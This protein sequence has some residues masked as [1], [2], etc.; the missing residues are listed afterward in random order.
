[1]GIPKFFR[2][3]SGRY[4]LVCERVTDDN[5]PEFDNLYLDMNGIIH[6][7]THPKDGEVAPPATDEERF[8][9][10][11]YYIDFLFN[12]IQPQ[13]VFF[14]GIDGV[15]PRAKMNEQRARRFR[16]A[17]ELEELQAKELRERRA[18][19]EM[20]VVGQHDDYSDKVFDPTC[21]TP[22]TQF[23]DKLTEALRYYIN[24]RVSEDANWRKPKII[25][26]APN[27]P[28]EGEHKIMDY[29]R[30]SRAQPGYRANTRHCLY[31][32]DAD[33]IMLGLLSHEPHFSLLREE[34]LFG[35]RARK[36]SAAAADPSMQAFYLLHISVLRDYLDHEFG[37]LRKQLGSSRQYEAIAAGQPAGTE[38]NAD[39]G[40]D[41]DADADAFDL[42]RII[43]DYVLMI[44]LVGNDFLPT[45]PKLSINGGALNFMFATYTRIRPTLGGYLHD[46][47]ELHLGRF[48][49]FMRELARVEV[50]SFKIE[51][52][53]HQ[54]YQVYKHKA[55]LRGETPDD[56]CVVSDADTS[57][58]RGGRSRRRGLGADAGPEKS[59]TL[60]EGEMLALAPMLGQTTIPIK[61]GRIVISKSQRALVDLIRRF[62]VRALPKVAADRHKVQM[63]YL[64]GPASALDNLVV[65]K[66]AELLELHV[67][68]EYAHNGSMTLHVAAGSPRALARLELEDSG[69]AGEES[70]ASSAAGFVAAAGLAP[71][72]YAALGG[73]EDGSDAGSDDEHSERAAPSAR[74][75]VPEFAKHVG[76]AD[77]AAAVAA[78]VNAR[79]SEF[80][81]VV[82]VADGELDAYTRTGDASDFWQRLELWKANYYRTKLEITYDVP[83]VSESGSEQAFREPPAAVEPMSRKYIQSLQWVLHYY[84]RGCP[85]WSWFYPYHYAPCISDVCAGL[86]AYR[87][88]QFDG[89]APYTPYEQLMCVLPPFSRKLLPA[90][91]R[92]LMVDVHSAIRDMFP[93]TF[94][95]DMNGKKMPWEAVVLIDFVDIDR[96][97][98]AMAPCLQQLSDDETHRNS[99]GRTMQYAYAAPSEESSGADGSQPEYTPPASL[100]F[101]P[102]RPLR[103]KG[104]LFVMPSL[105]PRDGHGALELVRGLL[106]GSVTRARMRPGFPSLFT[107]P[108][109]G[110]LGFNATEVFGFPSKDESLVVQLQPDALSLLGSASDAARELLA[111]KHVHGSYRPRRVFVSWPYLHDAVLVGVS[112]EAGVHTIDGAGTRVVYREHA[113]PAER[114]VWTKLYNDSVYQAKKLQA[115]VVGASPRMLLH[116]LPLRGMQMYP[117]G[118]L[119]R[120]YGFAD[121]RQKADAW[122]DVAAWP[123]LG[124]TT[125]HPNTVLTDL[126]GAW[127]NNPRFAE[128]DAAA[129]ERSLPAGDRVFF[130]GRTPLYGSP[131]KVVAHSRD[132]SGAVVGVDV[133]LVASPNI[134]SIK[135]A[136]FLGVSALASRHLGDRYKPSFVVARELG[137]APLLLSRITSKMSLQ[138]PSKYGDASRVHIGLDLKFEARRLKVIG[139]TKRGP[140]GW[141]FSDRAV[142]L[143]ASYM[144]AFPDMFARLAATRDHD[145][146]TAA[147]CFAPP[148]SADGG[149]GGAGASAKAHVAKQVERLKRWHKDNISHGAMVQVPVDTELLTKAEIDAIVS[150]QAQAQAHAGANKKILMS[151]VRREAVLRPADAQY[152][153]K[154]QSF[155]IGHR[156]VY[157]SD[158]S[159]SVPLGSKGYIVGL[160]TKEKP[161]SSDQSSQGASRHHVASVQ[162]QQQQQEGVS[163][164]MIQMVEVVFDQEFLDGSTL[165]GRCPPSRGALL[166]PYQV[167]DLTSWGLG[168]NV[169]SKPT[170]APRVVDA[171]KP[172]PNTVAKPAKSGK[173]NPRVGQTAEVAAKARAIL[174]RPAGAGMDDGT[175]S[176]NVPEPP[177]A[178]WA[179]SAQ[180]QPPRGDAHASKIISQL[181]SAM[182]RQGQSGPASSSASQPLPVSKEAHTQNIINT[183]LAG[184]MERM[185]VGSKPKSGP[186]SN[187]NANANATPLAGHPLVAGQMP[188]VIEEEYFSDSMDEDDHANASAAGGGKQIFYDYSKDN[189]AASANARRGGRG[190]GRGR[191]GYGRGGSSSNND[192]SNSNGTGN[193]NGAGT[194]SGNGRGGYRGRGSGRGGRGRS[195]NQ[196]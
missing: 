118:S 187:A 122:A 178:P 78:Y 46:N 160:H 98:A 102:V 131:A 55:R 50:D 7:C 130:I 51:V 192:N 12:K 142:S 54:W 113:T 5:I 120:D 194:G 82:V 2:W 87:V 97:R 153:L 149:R 91:L 89:D 80:D 44:M 182:T 190:R 195:S 15:A 176:V 148:Q 162:Q 57:K 177:R 115:V 35:A 181:T 31:G 10:I 11:F 60:S 49:T 114:S 23:M 72:Q 147:D 133:Q 188:L 134:G 132:A 112:D 19:G 186:S 106:R 189:A 14:L 161:A 139:Y 1:M 75:A 126:S 100:A 92:A 74:S 28:G 96:I 151:N 73:L 40:A 69:S 90:P 9:A 30:F 155:M 99:R 158:R 164:D 101:P 59:A 152:L 144:A 16:T 24:K 52:A 64:P 20:V 4:P 84:F 21:I 105:A 136:N 56:S 193:G 167:L 3:L 168:Q 83:D 125:H 163:A 26:S 36:A 173:P 42:E 37:G 62:A 17:K 183:L 76:D 196:Q 61:G 33:L 174:N 175:V 58:P 88:A 171:I 41:A 77:D 38:A 165:D 146:L 184:P 70:S 157:V 129:L 66:A 117:N 170:A 29:I 135:H 124:V 143:I 32:L 53:D 8:L 104:M 13:K 45:L 25:L 109:T 128:H 43:D 169:A 156:V 108:H 39:G 119:V 172:A 48:E 86:A 145:G 150:A 47:G 191:G 180:A 65:A 68:R 185:A 71:S 166:P 79:L 85:S 137:I 179:D 121:Q 116:V 110:G 63:Q 6:N 95:V 127:V 111:G 22:G 103:C 159:G 107:A 27:V 123:G 34:V 141:M 67:G 94:E 140:N 18:R 154:Q 81:D 93:T 138:D